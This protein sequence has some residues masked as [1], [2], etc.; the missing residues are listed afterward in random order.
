MSNHS[1]TENALRNAAIGI[2]NN[3]VVLALHLISRKLFLQYLGI[4]YL[5]VEQVARS[6]LSILSFS[7]MG[8][9]SAVLYMLYKPV[10]EDNRP[11]ITRIVNTFR[12][13]NTAVGLVIVVLG[14]CCL[15]FL[16]LFITTSVP[17]EEVYLI[18]LLR[19]AYSASSYF[20]A[21]RQMLI[22]A[23]Q[24]NRVV[25]MVSLVV[26]L[27]GVA[28]Q[29]V[30]LVTTKSYAP[31]ALVLV[32][33]SV[34][35]NLILYVIGGRLYPYL[36]ED[37]H[38]WI[39]RKSRKELAT[40][41]KSLF[42]V[43]VG[44][45]VINNTD[46]ILVSAIDTLTVGYMANYSTVTVRLKELLTIFHNAILYSL[47][48]ASVEKG[49][50]EKYQLFR[51]VVLIDQY[52]VGVI[53]VCTGVLWHDFI[54]VW[55]G[56]EY[57]IGDLLMYSVLLNFMWRVLVSPLA[58]FRDTN[59]LFVY[60]RRM[61]LVNAGL[62]IILSL[63]MGQVIGVPGV[64]IAT[65]I[66]DIL[67]DF[68]FDARLLYEKLFRRKGFW[69]YDL[70]AFGTCCANL[71]FVYLLRQVL[72]RL[73]V[74]ILMWVVKGTVAALS[75]TLVYVLVCGRTQVFRDVVNQILL[76]RLRGKKASE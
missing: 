35:Q 55:L 43:K 62:N 26:N 21:H 46:N 37:R 8:I 25:S 64:Y 36:K 66:A 40:Y 9:G 50:E 69:K 57:L 76:P 1:K 11:E 28:M 3:V 32:A 4:E 33:T 54:A 70:V 72:D 23:D 34:V 45:I 5:S 51:K 56:K 71:V 15:P 42:A 7:E 59:G 47:G 65:V 68:W 39:D 16:H 10:A 22:N 31:F 2:T 58:M 53:C 12:R 17:M 48:I 52:V 73:G 41:V 63:A 49:S 38:S 44:G 24:K 60:V 74:G 13:L 30:A 6:L 61:V 27:A 67:T 20:C 75:Y 18:F 29:C 14:V 19:L